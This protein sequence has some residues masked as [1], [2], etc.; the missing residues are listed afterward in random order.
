MSPNSKRNLTELCQHLD[1]VYYIQEETPQ[2]ISADLQWLALSQ[3]SP[4]EDL[5][6]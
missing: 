3:M 1:F 2:H 6:G 4:Q 5:W